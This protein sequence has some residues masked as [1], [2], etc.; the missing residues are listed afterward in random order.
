MP[1]L[2]RVLE[3]LDTAGA[4]LDRRSS[5]RERA[6]ASEALNFERAALLHKR[7]EKASDALRGLPELARRTENLDA[8]ILQRTAEE[9]TVA[10]FI[11]RGGLLDEPV[12]LRFGELSSQPKSIDAILRQTLQ[13]P[14]SAAG[15]ADKPAPPV[16][17]PPDSPV[18][19]DCRL[20]HHLTFMPACARLR[21]NW[22]KISCSLRA[23]FIPS[24]A[25]ARFFSAKRSGRTAASSGPSAEFS[26]PR[27]RYRPTRRSAAP[28]RQILETRCVFGEAAASARVVQ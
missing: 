6:E 27:Q 24:R 11:L 21:R 13:P 20:M 16:N 8:V 2:A 1:K 14:P 4:S 17:P 22:P 25:K 12:F 10:L 26:L 15:R 28:R 23:G 7:I 18:D 5:E 3:T 9:K 19:S